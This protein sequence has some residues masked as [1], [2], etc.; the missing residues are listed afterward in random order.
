MLPLPTSNALITFIGA[1][2]MVALG[3]AT[4]S[5]LAIMLGSAALLGLA[6]VFALTLPV[7][8]RLR[9]DRL[10]L[11]WW[12]TH[13]EPVAARGSVVAGARFEVQASLRHF[14][15]R[16]LVLSQLAPAHGPA[17][18]CVRGAQGAV[19]LPGQSRSEF[20]LGFVAVAPG[21]LVLHGLSVM[22]HGP[23]DLFRAPLY[24]P[25]P[26][27]IRALPRSAVH[28]NL[29]L[30]QSSGVVAERAGQVLRHTPGGGTEL[31]ELRELV[32]GDAFKTIAWK[33]SA[34]AG[35][36]MVRDVESEVQESLYLV[37]DISGTMR[38]GALGDRKLD[39][40]IEL[41]ASL[42]RDALARGD[43]AGVLT[44][45]GRVVGHTPARDGLSH[46]A[47][48]HEVLLGA[49]E[50]I[51]PDLTEADDEEVIA[52]VARYVRHQDGLDVRTSASTY[53]VDALVRH[54]QTAL[55]GEHEPR[56]VT[57][58]AIP[59]DPR[60][61][62]LRRFCRARGIDLRYRAETRGSA[63]AQ[64]LVQ[65]LRTAAGDSRVPR[66]I[67]VITDFDGIADTSTLEATVRMLR[68]R[69]HAL[70]FVVPQAQSLLAAPTTR[71]VRDLHLVYGLGESRRAKEMQGL[72]YKLGVPLVVS[73][74]RAGAR[75][76]LGKV[77]P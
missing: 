18:R 24:F 43:R 14:G 74:R 61:H 38:G 13:G 15:A 68:T 69:Q 59:S 27:V 33:A 1:C 36:L 58:P 65:A 30:R 73:A 71:L 55:T 26:L 48:L 53:D 77:A 32:P 2:A 3:I 37:L 47:R 57:K 22:V 20:E 4:S 39:Y 64:G 25:I 19:V 50:I 51:D 56:S 41:A 16:T 28:V 44:V 42:A 70:S 29:Q 31:R 46:M 21:R 11:A 45:D 75:A 17:L 49:T 40:A 12:H 67:V 34:R 54:A 52:L 10:E 6:S 72:L 76:A 66:S 60:A 7:G 23:L 9:R 35:K 63:K 62:V 5:A 8:A